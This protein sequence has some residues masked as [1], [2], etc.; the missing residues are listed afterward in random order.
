M[1]LFKYRRLNWIFLRLADPVI[2]SPFIHGFAQS[3]PP[4]PPEWNRV[5]SM[6]Y[7]VKAGL[8]KAVDWSCAIPVK[9]G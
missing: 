6:I 2:G 1:Y 7:V 3:K 5:M 4:D 8:R 9:G